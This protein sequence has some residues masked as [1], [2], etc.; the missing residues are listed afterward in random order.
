MIFPQVRK[1]PI[2]NAVCGNQE[3]QFLRGFHWS[4]SG[5]VFLTPPPWTGRGT[6]LSNGRQ[7][8]NKR[9]AVHKRASGKAARFFLRQRVLASTTGAEWESSTSRLLIL[10]GS[11]EAKVRGTTQRLSLLSSEFSKD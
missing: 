11:D 2:P 4:D 9:D 6:P 10:W 1:L 8:A 7:L 5:Q 3:G